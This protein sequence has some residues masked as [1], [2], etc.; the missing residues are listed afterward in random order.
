V[1]NPFYSA[2]AKTVPGLDVLVVGTMGAAVLGL[3]T[4]TQSL[5]I[6][7]ASMTSISHAFQTR[8]DL[9]ADRVAGVRSSGTAPPILRSIIWL[10][11]VA[12][13]AATV[14]FR[15]GAVW[16]ASALVPYALLSRVEPANQAWSWA[17]VYF[18]AVWIAA[19]VR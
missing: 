11:L 2:F 19:T 4:S 8:V 17:R 15:L 13:F 14:Y 10:L 9:E 18:A 12:S 16:A 3:A 7:A 1:L 6:M 5:L